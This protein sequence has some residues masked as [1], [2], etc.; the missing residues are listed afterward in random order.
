MKTRVTP[1]ALRR[2]ENHFFS[3]CLEGLYSDIQ[4]ASWVLLENVSQNITNAHNDK[5]DL[6]CFYFVVH[7][8]PRSAQN[9]QVCAWI[10]VSRRTLKPATVVM[11]GETSVAVKARPWLHNEDILR[12]GQCLLPGC[13]GVLH[14]QAI[15]KGII[16]SGRGGDFNQIT[17]TCEHTISPPFTSSPRVS[18]FSGS[19]WRVC[20]D[21]KH[22][23]YNQRDGW[24][25][26]LSIRM[27]LKQLSSHTP[28]KH[29]PTNLPHTQMMC[30]GFLS[31]L[32]FCC[33]PCMRT[34]KKAR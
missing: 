30:H 16:C 19:V 20:G 29:L 23:R 21:L 32:L 13:Q 15:R 2:E 14:T 1:D 9:K 7:F 25:L 3:I 31:Y 17:A 6:T 27:A 8:T 5:A 4:N 28:Y 24:T 11:R 10:C 34:R 18:S 33:L 22:D 26:L 12:D